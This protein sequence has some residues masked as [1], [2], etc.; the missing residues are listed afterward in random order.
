MSDIA[1][2]LD[3]LLY[4]AAI[5]FL[6]LAA[7]TPLAWRALRGTTHGIRTGMSALACLGAAGLLSL[8]FASSPRLEGTA[9]ATLTFSAVLQGAAAVILFLLPRRA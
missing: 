4:G 2:N 7:G 9:L 3:P 5:A 6:V 1:L 8:P